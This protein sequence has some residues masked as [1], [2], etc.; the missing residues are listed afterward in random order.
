M[1]GTEKKPSPCQ[2]LFFFLDANL[3]ALFLVVNHPLKTDFIYSAPCHK[4]TV[5]AAIIWS[6]GHT[7]MTCSSIKSLTRRDPRPSDPLIHPQ[8]SVTPFSWKAAQATTVSEYSSRQLPLYDVCGVG[9]S[10]SPFF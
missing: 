5:L 10:G 4:E 7:C 9:G 8:L 2:C 1:S 3:M 6:S